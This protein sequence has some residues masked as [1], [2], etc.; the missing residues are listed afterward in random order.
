[1]Q[2]EPAVGS[3][4]RSLLRTIRIS[5]NMHPADAERE[6]PAVAVMAARGFIQRHGKGRLLLRL[7]VKGELHLDGIMRAE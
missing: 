1:M 5:G 6:N 2:M 4:G 3:A 7:T